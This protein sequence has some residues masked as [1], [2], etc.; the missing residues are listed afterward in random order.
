[1]HEVG[2]FI[3][4]L[5]RRLGRLLPHGWLEPRPMSSAGFRARRPSSAQME[6]DPE[7]PASAW[8]AWEI[9]RRAGPTGHA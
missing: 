5:R 4:A 7:S 2:P 6:L 3:G 1:M 8:A 9:S